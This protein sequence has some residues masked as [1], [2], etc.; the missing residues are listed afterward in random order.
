MPTI[1][2]SVLY[3]A[4]RFEGA[5]QRLN[6][7]GT[8]Y[9]PADEARSAIAYNWFFLALV[10]HRLGHAEEAKLWLGKAV[11][12][13]E[14]ALPGKQQDAAAMAP[15]PWNRKLTLQLLRREAERSLRESK[16]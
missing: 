15:L 13:M 1:L 6:E 8:V 2:G 9:K 12:A 10:H 16:E 3:W 14:A 4:G 7:A 5:L 11:Q